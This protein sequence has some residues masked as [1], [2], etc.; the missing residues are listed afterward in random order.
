MAN[1]N[2]S[3]AT[4]FKPG[5]PGGP[6]RSKNWLRPGELKENIGRYCR[7]TVSELE[8]IRDNPKT[9]VIEV[10]LAGVL[11]RICEDPDPSKL[12]YVLNRTVGRV[13]EAMEEEADKADPIVR[14]VRSDGS[15]LEVV[16]PDQKTGTAQAESKPASE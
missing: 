7:L 2:P 3:P 13:V 10:I 16:R 15:I 6:G 11:L 5:N 14:I 8:K 12:E 1:K 9:S 4:Q